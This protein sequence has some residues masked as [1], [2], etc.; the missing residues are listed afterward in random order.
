MKYLIWMVPLTM[1]T[2]FSCQTKTTDHTKQP[3]PV[4]QAALMD[5]SAYMDYVAE[6]KAVQH[7]EIRAKLTGYLEKVHVDEGAHIKEGQLMFSIDDRE[8]KEQLAKR[9]ALLKSAKA[10]LKSNE[11]EL[12]N[13]RQLVNKGVVS[14]IELEFAKNKLLA[15]R[16][17][18]EEA[19]AEE[20]H[21]RLVLS[22]T[23]ITAPFDG[24]I[25]Q[26]PIK[27]G[28]LL[29]EGSLL[30]GLS[31]INEVFA[32][33]DISEKEYLEFMSKLTK[34]TSQERQVHLLLANGKMHQTSGTIETMS[35]QIDEQTGTLSFRARFKNPEEL[36]KHGASGKVRIA[37]K[38]KNVMVIPQK[39]T[40][41]IQD[42][43]YVY[44]IDQYGKARTR[45]ITIAYR[46]PHLYLI[47]KGITTKDDIIYEGLQLVND[48][49]R[50][51]KENV[52]F[53]WVLRD[54]SNF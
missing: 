20:E 45:A 38:F 51:Q 52:P 30:T 39:S 16:A 42:K 26:L 14:E 23:K 34:K 10:E 48:G 37:K 47:S 33:F 9:R 32:Y 41:E 19:Q 2:L 15:A 49:M 43:T 29:E 7:V 22:Y 53:K 11:L 1:T 40:F 4:I 24:V 54:L 50:I 18:V 44:V 21:A 46:L 31:K 8:Y 17:K 36:L 3:F 25:D 28:S 12:Q 35:G 6:I 13:T 27:V 5:T